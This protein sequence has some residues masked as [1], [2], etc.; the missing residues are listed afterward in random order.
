MFEQKEPQKSVELPAVDLTDMTPEARKNVYALFG[1]EIASSIGSRTLCQMLAASKISLWDLSAK[2]GF[3]VSLLSD[4]VLGKL[5][6]GPE[7]W[8]LVALGE[9]LDLDVDVS[10]STR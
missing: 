4:L 8:L 9:A 10:F 5:P 1:K 7:L 3:D 6:A 2:S